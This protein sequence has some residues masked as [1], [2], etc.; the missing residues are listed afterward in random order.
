MSGLNQ[1]DPNLRVSELEACGK[2]LDS[3]N[4]VLGNEVRTFEDAWALTC[5]AEFAIG[6]GNGL[7]AIEV[8][9]RALGIGPGDEV[10]TTPMTA[11]ATALGIIR[12]GAVPVFADIDSSTGLLSLESVESCISNRT[13]AVLLVHLY[14]QVRN[15]PAW[16]ELCARHGIELIEDCAQAHLAQSG[17]KYAGTFGRVGAYSFYPTKNLGAIGDAGAVVT[18]ETNLAELSYRL[19][20]YGQSERYIHT[21]IGLNSRLDEIQAALLNVRLAELVGYT[22]RRREIAVR[23]QQG[24]RNPHIRLLE[25]PE[26]ISAH[27]YHLFVV[28]CKDRVRLARH[29]DGLGIQTLMHYPVPLHLQPALPNPIVAPGGLQVAEHHAK[30]CLSIPCHPQLTNADVDYV[31]AGMNEFKG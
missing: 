11:M 4:F 16:L 27:S 3:G 25:K 22:E 17:G 31:I 28:A 13:K 9:I 30:T 2:V 7:D 14:G 23:Y 20:N 15:M 21:E 29:L 5:G 24:I 6:V 1:E 12:A 8:S 10:I 19:R 18:S 26:S